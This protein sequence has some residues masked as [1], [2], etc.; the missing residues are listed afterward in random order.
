MGLL[1]MNAYHRRQKQIAEVLARHGMGYLL[2]DVGLG[3]L[4]SLERR[5]LRRDRVDTRPEDLR[6]VLEE[7]GP[8]FIKLGQFVSTRRD[9]IP[10]V[11]LAEL[12]KL[13]D[14][15][16][17][18][19]TDVIDD[20]IRAELERPP[21]ELFATFEHVPLACA[22]IGQAHAAT[23]D[24]GTEVVV[25]VR[26]PGVVEEVE[27]DLA[28]L[29]N[30]AV[31]AFRRRDA[32]AQSDIEG[33]VDEFS[34]I[35]RAELD[36]QQE[37]TN[38][39]RFAANFDGD[40]SVQV[41]RVVRELTTSR[42][43]TLERIRGMK[44][45]DLPAL[46][47]AGIDRHALA[48][49]SAAFVAKSVF[50][51]G[52]F[53]GD[54]H[55]GN[56]FIELDGRLGV[57]DFGRVGVLDDQI[58][59]KL[60]R[61]LIAFFRGEPDHLASAVIDLG[62]SQRY[63]DRRLLADDLSIMLAKYA[64]ETVNHLPIGAAIRDLQDVVRHHHLAVPHVLTL[65]FTVF[66]MEEGLVLTLDPEFR[67]VA[68]LAPHVQR[69]IVHEL[70]ATEWARRVE[71]FGTD[72]AELAVDLPG[73]LHRLLD[74]VSESEGLDLRVRADELDPL[75]ERIEK[76]GNHI[77]RSILVAASIDA[78]AG[79]VV[80]NA[81]GRSWRKPMVAAGFAV[82]SALGGYEVWRRS[83]AAS[84]LRRLRSSALGRPA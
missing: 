5:A 17:A 13:Q 41:P 4:V 43:I 56:F 55:P 3:G 45:T 72:V 34:R 52:F 75:L 42:V 76:L 20:L 23:L 22:S 18:I 68:A 25:K 31:R 7:L 32:A 60:Q 16:P 39:E 19:P 57:I 81:R 47:A 59:A 29:R 64:D 11:Y 62:A 36:Y 14:R 70:W 63:V 74:L 35:L 26:R 1:S 83:P 44:I 73:Q 84:A 51:D 71:Q 80:E 10:P 38:A 53:H 77:A 50:E 37:A 79:F 2:E 30:L 54:P 46:S 33:L 12:E 48:E 78:M 9:I 21:S 24:D 67:L 65:L 58:R 40:A 6:A 8:T 61:L 66:V 27:Q 69:G 28:I 82:L 49:R 15:A